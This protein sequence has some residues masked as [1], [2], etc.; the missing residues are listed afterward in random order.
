MG[1]RL[2]IDALCPVRQTFRAPARDLP[3]RR[4]HQV[5]ILR[6]VS[7]FMGAARMRRNV[8]AAMECL[9]RRFDIAHIHFLTGEPAGNRV[10]MAGHG[11]AQHGDVQLCLTYLAAASVN[12]RHGLPGII[13][14]QLLARRMGLAHGDRELARPQ[15]VVLTKPAVAVTC[16]TGAICII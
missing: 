5:F 7:T 12:H 3:M 15:P 1:G 6:S 4:C 2:A 11:G 16:H 13:N 9:H 10:A 8:F 14:K